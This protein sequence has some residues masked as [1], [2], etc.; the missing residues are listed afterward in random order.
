MTAEGN[1]FDTDTSQGSD[2]SPYDMVDA[3]G[4]VM[5]TSRPELA[6]PDPGVDGAGP[7]ADFWQGYQ[8]APG[9]G[10]G[11]T[12]QAPGG[13]DPFAYTNGSLL[14]PWSGQFQNPYGQAPGYSPVS[15]YQYQQ[16]GYSPYAAQGL[17]APNQ[18]QAPGPF[19]YGQALPPGY[20]T[21][22]PF[23]APT[24]A[25]AQQNPGYQFAL[26]TGVGAME[27]S[28]SAKG[29]TGSPATLK[30]INDYAQNFA[31]QNYANVLNQQQGIYGLNTQ[32]GLQGYQANL[33]GQQQGYGQA[34]GTAQQNAQTDLNYNQANVGNQLSAYQANQQTALSAAQLNA[35]QQ[36]AAYNVNAQQG[37]FGYQN[38]LQQN[39]FGAQNAQQQYNTNYGNALN[40]YMLNYNQ[41]QTNQNNQYSR[42][43]GQS[44]QGLQAAG[45]LSGVGQNFAQNQGGLLEGQGNAN[46]AGQVGASNAW[47]SA[48]GNIGSLGAGLGY[49]Y[50]AGAFNTPPQAQGPAGYQPGNYVT[51][52]Y[53]QSL[54]GGGAGNNI[55]AWMQPHQ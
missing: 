15:P 48:L 33:S 30:A 2:S 39:Q 53:N 20:Q 40:E 10:Q 5:G 19:N 49:A 22:A 52:T 29:L 28:A 12:Q 16:A 18:L 21:P 55:G 4:N 23:Q 54:Q 46:A 24:L 6:P 44:Q 36:Q 34:L 41:F 7:A 25:Q 1:F 47:N 38:Q 43:L 45:A 35:Q 9:Q 26:Q 42:L 17:Q 8:G 27:S 3:E 32:T 37:Q 14:T 50:G 51:P 31:Q 13:A 11:Q